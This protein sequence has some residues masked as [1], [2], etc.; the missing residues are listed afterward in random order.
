[1]LHALAHGARF[2]WAGPDVRHLPSDRAATA[3]IASS[4]AAMAF[5]DS[6][7]DSVTLHG[8]P[9]YETERV[10]S[11]R[12][13][14]AVF[15][16]R[17]GDDH[18]LFVDGRYERTD[19]AVCWSR[20]P[21]RPGDDAFAPVTAVPAGP[22]VGLGPV[23]MAGSALI[24]VETSWDVNASSLRTVLS[25]DLPTHLLLRRSSL[26]GDERF[27]WVPITPLPKPSVLCGTSPGHAPSSAGRLAAATACRTLEPASLHLEIA[28]AAGDRAVRWNPS[29]HALVVRD[30]LGG[31][32]RAPRVGAELRSLAGVLAHARPRPGVALAPRVRQPQRLRRLVVDRPDHARRERDRQ[33]RRQRRA[34]VVRRRP[35]GRH[36]R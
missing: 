16:D 12:Y 34:G 6:Y 7:R 33:P 30:T 31:R 13:E 19:P 23:R 5:E 25:F 14:N 11:K 9:V 32:G 28:D 24:V 17:G 35:A 2:A 22:F 29:L 10:R 15:H 21:N 36:R 20:G 8:R 18:E 4:N 1:M 26:Y 3:L 27:S